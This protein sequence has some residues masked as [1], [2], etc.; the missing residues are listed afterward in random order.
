MIAKLI[1]KTLDIVRQIIIIKLTS[2]IK[3]LTFNNRKYFDK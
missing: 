3:I 1:K 2:L